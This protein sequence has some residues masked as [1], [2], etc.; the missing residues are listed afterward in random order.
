MNLPVLSRRRERRD[1]TIANVAEKAVLDAL[2]KAGKSP[3]LQGA[4]VATGISGASYPVPNPSSPFMQTGGNYGANPLPRPPS[5][6]ASLFGP[7]YPLFPDALDPLR[8]DGRAG[9]RRYQYRV[10]ENIQLVDR[11]VPWTTLRRVASEVDVVARCIE[12]VQDAMSGM[13]WQWGFSKQII[14]QIRVDHNEPNSGRAT[15]IARQKY[16]EELDRIQKFFARPDER[17]GYTFIQ[18][19]TLMVWAQLVYDGIAIYPSYTLKGE[20]HSLSLLDTSTIKLLLD[21]QGFTPQPPAP[22]FQQILYGFPRGEYQAE[23]AGDGS[24]PNG[25]KQDQL[26]YYIRRPRLHTHYGFSAVEESLN[27]ATLYAQRQEWMHAEWSHGVTP[28]MVVEIEG[29]ETWTPDQLAYYQQTTN[30]QWSGQ[31]Q[32]RQQLMVMRPGMKA[33]QLQEMAEVYKSDYDQWLVMQIGAKFGVPQMQLGIPMVL[34]NLGSGSQNAS[35]MDL[36]DKFSLDSLVNFLVDCIN[37]LARR[38]LGMGPEITITALH[39]NSDDA[40]LAQAQADASDVDH[41]I[42]TRNEIRAE[43]GIPLSTEPE[44]DELGVTT[45]TGVTFLSGQLDAQ[46]AQLAILQ[47]GGEVSDPRQRSSKLDEPADPANKPT[48]VRPTGSG[49]D[50]KDRPHSPRSDA[51]TPRPTSRSKRVAGPQLA[52]GAASGAYTV[53]ELMAFTN[54]VKARQERGTWRDFN[55]EHVS[56]EQ[57]DALNATGRSAVE[58]STGP[59]AAGIAVRAKDS[60]RVLLLQRA[61]MDDDPAAGKFEFPGGCLEGDEFPLDAAI[62]EWQEECGCQLPDGNIVGDWL[63]PNGVYQGYVYEI[64]SEDDVH[65]NLDADDRSIINPDDPDGDYPEYVAWLNPSALPGNA[66][67]RSEVLLTPFNVLAA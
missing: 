43:R 40:D 5:D 27:Y 59:K 23:A 9:P 65:I 52:T 30:D 67:L 10:T 57:A 32:R 22:A 45:A 7:G 3:A 16:G 25:F 62:R 60:G 4:P 61:L 51:K 12:L 38:F 11:D 63:S 31:T 64:E 47:Q 34:H 18:W 15:T 55:F 13:H 1:A 21:N 41:G 26:A 46:D 8:S 14:N 20:L 50:A 42:R 35:S 58:K 17:M 48:G 36:A 28:K 44:A 37:D 24:V 56:V 6:F 33:T 54:F 19:L 39:A 49:N 2:E 66:L 29:T 53:K